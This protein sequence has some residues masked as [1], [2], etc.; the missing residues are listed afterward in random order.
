MDNDFG[1]TDEAMT[2]GWLHKPTRIQDCTTVVKEYES[3]ISPFRK[4]N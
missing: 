1:S 3:A 4:P 2:A